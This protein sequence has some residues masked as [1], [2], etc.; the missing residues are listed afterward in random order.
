M[1]PHA[2]ATSGRA[3]ISPDGT[4]IAPPSSRNH[5]PSSYHD[6]PAVHPSRY[7]PNTTMLNTRR[8]NTTARTRQT[9]GPRP[10]PG[11]G[12]GTGS[13][14]SEGSGWWYAPARTITTPASPRATRV[15][16]TG[17]QAS[18]GAMP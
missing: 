12:G 7:N 17:M 1:H 15:R 2:R 3:T 18:G 13:G 5:F 11:G 10:D 9:G 14:G 6:S 8:N 16:Q 4:P